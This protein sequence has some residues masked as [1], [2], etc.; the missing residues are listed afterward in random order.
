MAYLPRPCLRR[1]GARFSDG[2]VDH[3]L[4]NLR[5]RAVGTHATGVRTLVAI[6]GALVI[7]EM[8]IGQKSVPLTKLIREN[9]P[10]SRKSSITTLAPAEPKLMVDEDVFK[11]TLGGVLVHGHGHALAGGQTIGLDDDWGAVLVHV[12][13]RHLKTLK[14]LYW[15]VGMLWRSMS[16]LAKSLEPSILAAALDGP[17]ALMPAAAKSSTMPSISGTSGP[18]EHPVVVVVFHEVDECGVIRPLKVWCGCRPEHAR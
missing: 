5:H 9:S 2:L 6:V 8:G 4:R 16:C 3:G 11:R 7:L 14:V 15:A 12:V 18:Y 10:P 13:L 17:N 1:W